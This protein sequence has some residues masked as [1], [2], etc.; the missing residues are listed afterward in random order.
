MKK[1]LKNILVATAVSTFCSGLAINSYAISSNPS[2]DNKLSSK[3]IAHA[4]ALKYGVVDYMAVFQ[5]VPQ[6]KDKL[7]SMK[8]SLQ[9]K[10]ESLK[11]QQAE[12]QNEMKNLQKDAPTLTNAQKQ[13]KQEDILKKQSDFQMK[14]KSMQDEESAKE[15]AAAVD[16][17]EAVKKAIDVV[18]K[19]DGYDLVFNSQAVPYSKVGFDL[20]HEVIAEMKKEANK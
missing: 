16:F 20:S 2:S 6:G 7:L 11:K 5:M 13:A 10:L 3:S 14:V 9:P 18:G 12:L 8:T 17:Q 4:A 1:V 19:K 15:Q